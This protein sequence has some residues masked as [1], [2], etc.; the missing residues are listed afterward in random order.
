MDI[1]AGTT[2]LDSLLQANNTATQKSGVDNTAAAIPAARKL[3]AKILTKDIVDLSKQDNQPQADDKKNSNLT[4]Q[5]SRLQ[6]DD[7]QI[8]E[9][10]YRRT[11][12]FINGEG[13]SFT[14]IEEVLNTQSRSQRTVVQQNPS[15]NT[16]ILEN[17]LDRQGDGSFRQTQ[18]FTD[19]TGTVNTNIKYNVTPSDQDFIV[20]KSPKQPL[21]NDNPYQLLRGT[22]YDISA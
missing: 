19:E 22:Q 15:G 16:T 5:Q 8:L 20:G 9:N 13:R 6:N 18:R 17:I 21:E 1:R 10:G 14:R 2:L 7:T 12:E 3:P 4:G 11:Q